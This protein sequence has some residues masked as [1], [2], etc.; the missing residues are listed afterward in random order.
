MTLIYAKDFQ[1]FDNLIKPVLYYLNFHVE[2]L[3]FD[4]KE[5]ELQGIHLIH[6]YK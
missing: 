5:L 4:K 3:S 6:R 1:L 2:L